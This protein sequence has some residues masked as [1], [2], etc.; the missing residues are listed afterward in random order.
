MDRLT[1]S[2]YG[3]RYFSHFEKIK[4]KDNFYE[5]EYILYGKKTDR[6]NL[7]AS[8]LKLVSVRQGLN[9]IHNIIRW[10]KTSGSRNAGSGYNRRW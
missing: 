9:M 8:V 5:L 3:V 1:V 6:E 2:E 10:K 4:D 7:E